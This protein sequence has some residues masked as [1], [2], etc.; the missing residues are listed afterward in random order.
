MLN[1]K[2]ES[3]QIQFS[4]INF[5]QRFYQDKNIVTILL[6]TTFYPKQVDKSIVNGT[7]EVTLDIDKMKS[8]KD[9]ENRAFEKEEI[10]VNISVS[11]DGIWEHV[12]FYDGKLVFKKKQKNI[13]EFVLTSKEAELEVNSSAGMVS[14]YSTSSSEKQLKELICMDEFYEV[15]IR[16]E[17]QKREILKYIVKN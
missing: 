2:K 13:I 14:L 12:T 5:R 4:E 15:P 10:K 1:L 6:Q 9:L 3:F 17:I 7:I 16:K 11:K 8:L